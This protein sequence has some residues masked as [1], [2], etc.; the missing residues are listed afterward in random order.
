MA[1]LLSECGREI[2]ASPPR[3]PAFTRGF[4][5]C[6]SAP[7]RASPSHVPH[8][9]GH[10]KP[11]VSEDA[12]PLEGLRRRGFIARDDE[13]NLTPEGRAHLADLG[14]AFEALEGGRRPL[15]RAC[16][17]WSERR[18]HLGGA[19]GAALLDLMQGQ[20]WLQREEGRVL[21]FTPAGT[22]A[23]EAAFA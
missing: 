3:R 22:R 19:L 11:I 9:L 21:R 16:L 6:L 8:H 10:T 7:R 17:D 2:A 18:A 4:D 20:N 12:L 15:C 13:L 23:F 1:T 5:G 14:V